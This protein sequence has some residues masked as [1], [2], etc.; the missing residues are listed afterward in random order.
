MLPR[1]WCFCLTGDGVRAGLRVD[2]PFCLG[3]GV[4]DQPHHT[5]VVWGLML[6]PRV[7]VATC[8]LGNSWLG[9]RVRIPRLP[10][11]QSIYPLADLDQLEAVVAFS[12]GYL[13][14]L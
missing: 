4:A 14:W 5:L 11:L 3:H 10:G 2:M 13:L 9:A 7:G 8:A 12:S 1:P 6:P